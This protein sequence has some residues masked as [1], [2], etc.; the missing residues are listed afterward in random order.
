MPVLG[1]EYSG[2]IILALHICTGQLQRGNAVIVILASS[3]RIYLRPTFANV[4]VP[5]KG[6]YSC[7]AMQKAGAKRDEPTLLGTACCTLLSDAKPFCFTAILTMS[8]NG[9]PAGRARWEA[10]VHSRPDIDRD[11][12]AKPL[13][14]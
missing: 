3:D 13:E 2:Y 14:R 7:L 10:E 12:R 4:V 9:P 11:G 5:Y 1:S 6:P 8:R